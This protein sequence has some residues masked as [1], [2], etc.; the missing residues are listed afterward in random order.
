MVDGSTMDGQTYFLQVPYIRAYN[1]ILIYAITTAAFCLL[2]VFFLSTTDNGHTIYTYIIIAIFY[3]FRL[4]WMCGG[5]THFHFTL[6]LQLNSLLKSI[7]LCC[8]DRCLCVFLFIRPS[9]PAAGP[10]TISSISF[11]DGLIC[12]LCSIFALQFL[13]TFFLSLSLVSLFLS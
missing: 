8:I 5:V 11:S 2:P 6:L 12:I 4:D 13:S 10:S 7:Y 1:I 3:S 9:C